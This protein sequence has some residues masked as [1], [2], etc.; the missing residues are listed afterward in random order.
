MARRAE[1]GPPGHPGAL[2]GMAAMTARAGGR[3]AV[4]VAEAAR[5]GHADAERLLAG[6]VGLRISGTWTMPDP[7]FFDEVR[8][9][10]GKPLLTL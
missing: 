7:E 3:C 5:H 10:V 8:I 1:S 4:P 2:F 9:G 6:T